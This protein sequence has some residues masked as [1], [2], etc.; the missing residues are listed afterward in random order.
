MSQHRKTPKVE[1]RKNKWNVM[2]HRDPEDKDQKGVYDVE[3]KGFK[4]ICLLGIKD[5]LRQEVPG[6][7]AKCKIAGVRVRMVT[8]DNLL[9]AAIEGVYLLDPPRPTWFVVKGSARGA[10][11][12]VG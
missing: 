6:A 10:V 4:M 3:T 9:T 7:I 1:N 11:H 2:G 5:I 8:G 12:V